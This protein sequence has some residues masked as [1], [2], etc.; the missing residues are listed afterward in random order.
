MALINYLHQ[1]EKS[2]TAARL[3][4]EAC[5]WSGKGI[6]CI[7][8][9]EQYLQ[10]LENI[11]EKTQE[12]AMLLNIYGRSLSPSEKDYI[13]EWLGMG[14]SPDVIQTAYD[15]TVIKTGA[16]NWK[17]LD[18]ILCNWHKDG[19]HSK[20]ELEKHKLTTGQAPK[21]VNYS[22]RPQNYA[23]SSHSS[24]TASDSDYYK[25]VLAHLKNK[26]NE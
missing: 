1:A 9:V 5:I 19:I 16:L 18:T 12:T 17:Y 24:D 3:E 2:L 20:K 23:K 11:T 7:E 14:F 4:K 15:K 26:H 13:N 21:P 25:K 22:D 10:S 6:D 8:K